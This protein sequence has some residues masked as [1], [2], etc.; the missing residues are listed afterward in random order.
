MRDY[1][2]EYLEWLSEEEL[3]R[4]VRRAELAG[5]FE[6][7]AQFQAKLEEN[8]QRKVQ[9]ALRHFESIMLESDVPAPYGL[10]S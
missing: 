9:G 8:T 7:A 3:I 6:L 1:W 2:Q 10:Q 4:L 5:K